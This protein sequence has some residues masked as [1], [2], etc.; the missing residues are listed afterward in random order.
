MFVGDTWKIK[1]L[2]NTRVIATVNESQFVTEAIAK[3]ATKDDPVV[4]SVD[5]EGIN[6][7]LKG[8]LTLV[9]I[10]TIRG[11]AFIFDVQQ[12]PN[13]MTEGGLKGLLENENVIKIIHDCRNDS[14]N[15]FVQFR[16]LL[17]NVFDTQV[18]FGGFISF[19]FY[20]D[21][22]CSFFVRP[23]CIQ[24]NLACFP[25]SNRFS[26]FLPLHSR[27]TLCSSI[28]NKISKF[29]KSKMFH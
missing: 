22:F 9:E 28:K 4:I 13:I 26:G 20:S 1:V 14:V 11:E 2:Q 17:R 19:V 21:S 6:L 16:V 24:S 25:N 18:S 27:L 29:T 15:L 10:G 5:C 23:L 12:C 8:E 7:G 3:S